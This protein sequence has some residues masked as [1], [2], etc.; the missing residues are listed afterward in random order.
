MDMVTIET[1]KD[2]EKRW[3]ELELKKR[4]VMTRCEQYS[5][6]T[7]PY[8]FPRENSNSI[9]LQNS[10]D[11]LGARGV[12]HLS[13]RIVM[14]LFPAQTSFFRLRL[15]QETKIMIKAA[16]AQAGQSGDAGRIESMFQDQLV[17][18][19]GELLSTEKQAG[20]HLDMVQ[21]RPQ[22]VMAAKSLIITGNALEYHPDTGPVQTLGLRDYCIQRDISGQV[23]EIMTREKKAYETFRKEVQDL[24]KQSP[25]SHN[26]AKGYK[27]D[28]DVTVYT[29][30]LLKPDGKFHV[31]QSADWVLLDTSDIVYTRKELPWVPLVWNLVHGEDYGRGLIEEYSG[32]FHAL[33]VLNEALLN[34]AAIMSDIKWLVK[35]ASLVDV[36]SMNKAPSGSYHAGNPEDVTPIQLNKL[37]DAQ[38]IGSMIERYERQLYDAFLLSSTRQAERVT[39]E[40][41]RR[42]ANEL[43]ISNG[44][45]YSRLAATWQA[46]VAYIVLKQIKFE[47]LDDGITPQIVTGM[48][49]LSRQAE[50]DNYKLWLMDL[51]LLENV[52]EDVRGRLKVSNL[53]EIMGQAR[54]IDTA[55]AILSEDEYAQKVAEAQQAQMQQM[56]QEQQGQMATEVGKQAMREE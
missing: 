4:P 24:L 40:E 9:E 2:L 29:Q 48:D 15:D 50:M 7:L 44:G 28:T 26:K 10:I 32:A 34:L 17:K 41:I 22:A 52:P 33:T 36:D 38:Y 51:A 47:G 49:S 31:Y 23:I 12:N 42:D 55:R 20:E 53:A 39:A 54:Q 16:L 19:E 35:P 43:E 21:Y 37:Q 3:S 46:P 1:V 18:L 27:A 11:S 25:Q 30:V 6:W 13:N 14:T 8:V 45:I 5:A 56:Q